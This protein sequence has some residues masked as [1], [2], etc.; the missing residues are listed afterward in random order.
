MDIGGV[1]RPVT[2]GVCVMAVPER[3]D[4]AQAIQEEICA[5]GGECSVHYDYERQGPWWNWRRSMEFALYGKEYGVVLQ[6]DVEVCT[7]FV[8]ALQ[9]LIQATYD[10]PVSLFTARRSYV[11]EAQRR[12]RRLLPK[13]EC[14]AQALMMPGWLVAQA[15]EWIAAHEDPA[16][17]NHDDTRLEAWSKAARRPFVQVFPSLANHGKLKSTMGHGMHRPAALYVAGDAREIDWGSPL[18]ER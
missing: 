1:V 7:G 8:G 5:Q 17:K 10:R 11:Q 14:T 18:E 2:V 13:Y 3:A 16:W 12:R 6:D 9:P 4:S 15:V